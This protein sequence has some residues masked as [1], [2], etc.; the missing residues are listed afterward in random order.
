MVQETK[1]T[2]LIEGKLPQNFWREAVGAVI[3]IF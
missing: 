2:M 1:R 3:Y